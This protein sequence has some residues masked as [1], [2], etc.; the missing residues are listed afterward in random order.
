MSCRYCH[1][2][3][4]ADIESA[5]VAGWIWSIFAGQYEM[6]EPVCPIC[7]PRYLRLADD[8]NWEILPTADIAYLYN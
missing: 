6:L 2:T 3:Q 1:R 8:G 7:R 4:P 5:C